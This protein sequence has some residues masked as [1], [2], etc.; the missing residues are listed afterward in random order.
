MSGGNA[1]TRDTEMRN[2]TNVTRISSSDI[3]SLDEK[4]GLSLGGQTSGG[5]G[6]FTRAA[7]DKSQA[8]KII[9]Y[10]PEENHTVK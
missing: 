6:T 7:M 1:K 9:M 4:Q 8:P 10:Y 2:P 5:N 3:A